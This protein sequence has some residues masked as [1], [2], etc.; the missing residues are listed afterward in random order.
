MLY[1]T[2][3]HD[4]TVTTCPGGDCAGGEQIC[5]TAG[6]TGYVRGYDHR[7]PIVELGDEAV[8]LA[9]VPRHAAEIHAT[10]GGA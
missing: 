3:T 2:I 10:E 5:I 4:M 7:D 9:I 8:F 1:A 6:E